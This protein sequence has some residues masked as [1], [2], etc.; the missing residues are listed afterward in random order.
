M[1]APPPTSSQSPILNLLTSNADLL[2]AGPS[3][4]TGA[5]GATAVGVDR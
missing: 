1:T 4:R 2:L 3:R 5:S